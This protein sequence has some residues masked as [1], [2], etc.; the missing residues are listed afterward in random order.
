MSDFARLGHN[1]AMRIVLIQPCRALYIRYLRHAFRNKSI[2]VGV[3]IKSSVSPGPS[4]DKHDETD[5]DWL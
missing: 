4:L 5:S 2:S 1:N 3:V